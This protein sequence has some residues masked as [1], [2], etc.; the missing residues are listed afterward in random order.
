MLLPLTYR[1][2]PVQTLPLTV[3]PL[4]SKIAGWLDITYIIIQ[5][6]AFESVDILAS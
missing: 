6:F 4:N 5:M 1:H 3:V 2:R